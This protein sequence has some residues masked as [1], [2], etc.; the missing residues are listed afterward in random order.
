MYLL[1]KNF[2]SSPLLIF[3]WVVYCS[4]VDW[5]S[6]LSSLVAVPASEGDMGLIPRSGRF[7][8]KGNGNTLQYSCLGNALDREAWQTTVH[9]VAKSQM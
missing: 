2:Y 5:K 7:S 8:G 1:W 4:I 3:N 9:G 6:S